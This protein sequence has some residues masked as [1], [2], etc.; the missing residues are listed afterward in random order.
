MYWTKDICTASV[1]T[2]I[3]PETVGRK[4][5]ESFLF[6]ECTVQLR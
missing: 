2:W 3:H 5:N 4:H 1:K 6:E